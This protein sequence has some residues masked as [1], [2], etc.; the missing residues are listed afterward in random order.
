MLPL[1][2]LEESILNFSKELNSNFWFIILLEDGILVKI[3]AENPKVRIDSKGVLFELQREIG[4][5]INFELVPKG[6]LFERERLLEV[7][8]VIK[9]K[10]ITDWRSDG[11]RPETLDR[12]MLGYH[13]FIEPKDR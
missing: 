8:P 5:P 12:L 9:P 11:S 2:I 3:E 4:I 1:G 13:T 7:N 10:Y 6:A